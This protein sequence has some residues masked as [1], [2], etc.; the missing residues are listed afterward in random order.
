MGKCHHRPVDA[1][2]AAI[3]M[4]RASRD[5]IAPIKNSFEFETNDP[6]Q[7]RLRLTLLPDVVAAAADA[8]VT[9]NPRR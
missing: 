9:A 5:R 7:P 3:A 6:K 1:Y 2:R 4:R 8:P